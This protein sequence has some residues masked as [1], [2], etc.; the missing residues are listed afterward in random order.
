MD[1]GFFSQITPATFS[2]VMSKDSVYRN[3]EDGFRREKPPGET[4]LSPIAFGREFAEMFRRG[5]S[6]MEGS[7]GGRPCPWPGENK[8]TVAGA[9]GGRKPAYVLPSLNVCRLLFALATGT[10]VADVPTTFDPDYWLKS[11]RTDDSDE[12]DA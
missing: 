2:Q 4:L 5:W 12:M 9:P 1:A 7:R 8:I 6:K 11:T 3:Y 10:T